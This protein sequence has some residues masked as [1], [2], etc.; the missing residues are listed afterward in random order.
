MRPRATLNAPTNAS[1]PA[2]ITYVALALVLVA[3]FLT[4]S[5]TPALQEKASAGLRTDFAGLA[6][7]TLID[8]T[9]L[10]QTAQIFANAVN[11][12]YTNWRGMVFG[13]LLGALVLSAWRVAPVSQLAQRIPAGTES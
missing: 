7:E 10:S 3:I 9:G 13:I 11:W 5:R 12:Y 4:T 2:F 1:R 6:F 8:P